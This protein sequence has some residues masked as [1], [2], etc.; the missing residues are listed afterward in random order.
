M[1]RSSIALLAAAVLV[2]AAA[3][4]DDKP[5]AAPAAPAVDAGAPGEGSLRVLAADG[6]DLTPVVPEF[7]AATGCKVTIEPQGTS[8]EVVRRA[9]DTDVDVFAVSGDS[10]LSLAV[11][12]AAAPVPKGADD[13]VIPAVRRVAER[14]GDRYG[15]PFAWGPEYLLSTRRAFPVP[16]TSF[17]S[18]Y[19]PA[20][21]GRIAVPDDPLQIAVAAVV[22][23]ARDPYALDARSLDAAAE[24]VR[25]QRPLVREYWSAPAD[26]AALFADGRVVLGQA[27]GKVAA[28]LSAVG[29]A[30]TVPAGPALAWSSWLVIAKT[31]P[32]PRCAAKWRNYVLG[33]STQIALARAASGAPAVRAACA[34]EGP[35]S[36]AVDRLDDEAFL[37]SLRVART[38]LEPTGIAA[39]DR[40]GALRAASGWRKL[41]AEE[42]RAGRRAP[43]LRAPA[44]QEEPRMHRHGSPARWSCAQSRSRPPRAVTRTIRP[45]WPV[46]AASRRRRRRRVHLPC[47]ADRCPR[48][49]APARAS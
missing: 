29:V 48:R 39:W 28:D 30:A 14:D 49:S 1:R 20:Y 21:A 3:C 35:V 46:A 42:R 26:L 19:D 24:L 4:G 41:A 16:P 11:A 9:S 6:M 32:H 17:D 44:G 10:V 25:R 27:R 2:T 37:S 13:D 31:A 38:P 18:L 8:A 33:P 23:D 47:W 34:I 22:L 15:V 40:P 5:A 12:G 43:W 36:C 45:L 7:E